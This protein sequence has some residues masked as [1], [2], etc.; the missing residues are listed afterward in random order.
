MFALGFW[1]LK[2]YT[3]ILNILAFRFI[4]LY[5]LL[6]VTGNY[7]KMPSRRGTEN[8]IGFG[9]DRGGTFTGAF[10]QNDRTQII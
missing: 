1:C 6:G 5:S 10:T 2:T 3:F 4:Y 8:G 7:T 9:I